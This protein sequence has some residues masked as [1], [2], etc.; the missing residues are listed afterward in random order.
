MK[1]SIFGLGII[2]SAW[3]QHY[4]AAGI[5]AATWNRTAKPAAPA[6]QPSALA[7][8]QAGDLW[9]IVIADPPAVAAVLA[10]V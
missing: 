8:A 3:A 4:S 1:V 2:G 9:Q 10:Y 5:L 6:W 7:A